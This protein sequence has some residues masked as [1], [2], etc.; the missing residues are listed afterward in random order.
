M[1]RL[2]SDTR[3]CGDHARCAFQQ[4]EHRG[5]RRCRSRPLA[6]SAHPRGSRRLVSPIAPRGGSQG[7]QAA[8]AF[9]GAQSNI[10]APSGSC[11]PTL[12]GYPQPL[13]M[14]HASSTLRGFS[15][16]DTGVRD[17]EGHQSPSM[18]PNLMPSQRHSS[19]TCTHRIHHNRPAQRQLLLVAGDDVEVAVTTDFHIM[20]IALAD[21][22]PDPVLGWP[23]DV[24]EPLEGFAP[25]HRIRSRC[26]RHRR[27]C[28]LP[29]RPWS[30][31]AGNGMLFRDGYW[32]QT[33]RRFGLLGADD[34]V[35]ASVTEEVT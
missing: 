31:A 5:R 35:E 3:V 6:G 23:E 20:R 9:R 29:D 30:L 27:R 18:S 21:L 11:P 26:R 2:R 4:P 17:I 16:H 25:G 15:N 12:R 10:D 7:R 33:S 22:V 14:L 19:T 13:S 24:L 34:D 1:R 28:R 32:Y 8:H